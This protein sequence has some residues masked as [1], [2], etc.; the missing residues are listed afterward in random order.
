[1][2]KDM[3]L[4]GTLGF[5]GVG[6]QNRRQTNSVLHDLARNGGNCTKSLCDISEQN[7]AW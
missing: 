1:M 3:R 6:R 4:D 5:A 7:P 2:H